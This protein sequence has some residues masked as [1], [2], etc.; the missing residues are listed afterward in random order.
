MNNSTLSFSSELPPREWVRLLSAKRYMM[1]VN[2]C[3]VT[4][5][6]A[7][8]AFSWLALAP[9]LV[10]AADCTQTLSAGANVASAVS[11]AAAGSTIC[12]NNGSYSGFTLNG[13]SKNPRVTVLAVN[14]LGASFTGALAF[15]GNTNGL[16]FDGF[17]FTNVTITGASTR[18]LTFRNYNQTGKF[19]IDG[20]TTATP[21]ILL[22]NF[23]H[24]NVT[25]AQ[26][27]NARINFSFS[28]RSTPV[29][30]IRGATID[31]GCADG[32]Q[33]GVPFILE[34]STLKNMQV[35]S[36]PN[37]PHT[38]A[39]Q[40]YGGPFAGT[41]IRNNYFYRNVQVLT[42]YD[43]VDGVLID[44]NIFDPGPDGE[45]RPCQ[46]ELYSDANS[47]IR[48]N[49]ILARGSQYGHICLDRKTADDAGYG[50]IVVDNIANSIQTVNG[51]TYSQRTKNL[52]LS[53]A[54]SGE[55]SGAPIYVGGST[56]TTIAGFQ[57]A[58]NSVGKGAASSPIGS[59][60]G[61]SAPGS[62]PPP[63]VALPAPTNVQI[64]P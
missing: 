29:A 58:A 21:N 7:A 45:R 25:A 24:N 15:T 37:D 57:L 41:I 51:S 64:I 33:S 36:C 31:G 43:G 4:G 6:G 53:G 35:G 61:A 17:N 48:H 56:P 26:A 39:L 50:T 59:D 34:Y 49:T 62:S 28:G 55:I 11:S 63:P 22:E 54:I 23:T 13:V 44:N 3:R 2:P 52:L 8:L 42:A 32:I 60:I 18:E 40:L 38:D 16:T 27:T 46:I 12:L 14:P 19:L 5:S 10:L 30:T 47:I 20:V 1:L 9:S